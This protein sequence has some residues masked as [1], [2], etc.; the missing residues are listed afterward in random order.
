MAHACIL[1]GCECCCSG[2]WD[3][4]IVSKTPSSCEGCGCEAFAKD[5]GLN[6]DYDESEFIACDKC[7]G[8]PAC[9]D[10]G[11]AIEAGIIVHS[12]KK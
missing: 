9:E 4:T 12:I 5:Q 6:D 7:D 3:D 8:H 2:D 1:C 10:F 11:C